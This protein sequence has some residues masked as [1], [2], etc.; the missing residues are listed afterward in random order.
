MR[1][2]YS[3]RSFLLLETLLAIAMIGI[4]S[5]YVISAPMK[6]Y[7]NHLESLKKIELERIADT[8]F[9]KIQH[10]LK[11]TH[12]WDSLTEKQ[13]NPFNLDP[14][15]LTISPILSADYTCSYTLRVKRAKEGQGGTFYKLLEC[16]IHMTPSGASKDFKCSY[17]IFIS[18]SPARQVI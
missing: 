10:H 12:S 6:V 13:S 1:F 17:L 8:L 14:I 11:E 2:K 4:C 7:Q 18:G 16:V 3:R 5:S 9:V 15:Q